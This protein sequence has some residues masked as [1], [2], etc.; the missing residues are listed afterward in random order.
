[1]TLAPL[2]LK[3]NEERRITGGHLWV[4]SN[5]VDIAQ[6]PLTD[7]S[8]GQSVAIMAHNG[9][10][11]G[12]GYVNP[13]SL[14]CARMVSRDK[15]YHLDQSLITHRLK[16][17]L[18]LREGLFDYPCYRLVHGESDLL[19]GLVVD[20]YFDTL[21]VQLGTAGMEVLKEQVITALQKVL[22]PRAILLRNDG[23]IRKMEGLDSY[24]ECVLGELPEQVEL[25][26]N[27]VKFHAPLQGGQKTGWFYD[28]RMNRARMMSYVQGKRVLDIFS[29]IGGWGVQAAVAGADDVM[30]ID[31]SEKALDLVQHN[32][33]LNGVAEKMATLQGDAF[34]AMKALR[35]EREH[36]D[37]IVLDPPAFIKRRKDIK[38]GTNAYRRVNQMAMQLLSKDG[39]LISGSCSHHLS[40]DALQSVMQKSAS[41]LDRNLQILEQGHQGPD[42]PVHPVIPETDY[43]KAIFSRVLH[44]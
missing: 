25:I 14:I 15:K 10:C 29:Y 7:F 8:P 4:Y 41:H 11:L 22:K 2:K 39:I 35:E 26:E 38:E 36:F 30:C 34:D 33:E 43:L 6:T 13:H 27:G 19:P 18:S 16:I 42:H 44:R 12:N 17:A 20:R 3:K 23:A 37:V 40:R 32:G 1:M 31:V 24:I 28:H 5:E 9:K 21:V